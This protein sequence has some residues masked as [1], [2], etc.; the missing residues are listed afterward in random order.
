MLFF[1]CRYKPYPATDYVIRNQLTNM[2]SNMQGTYLFNTVVLLHRHPG[3]LKDIWS[4]AIKDLFLSTHL[5]FKRCCL[6]RIVGL[7]KKA[8]PL[9][10]KKKKKCYIKIK[11]VL[12]NKKGRETISRIVFL[13]SLRLPWEGTLGR[14]TGT[15]TACG[16]VGLQVTSARNSKA[17]IYIKA[18]QG[19]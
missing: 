3:Q 10:K 14:Q 5:S 2:T 12:N 6:A 7:P 4:Y 13:G 15:K 17:G 1:C 19:K 18:K 16:R 11:W 9:G 8:H